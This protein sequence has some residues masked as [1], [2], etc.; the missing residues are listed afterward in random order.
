MRHPGLSIPLRRNF[1]LLAAIASQG[2]LYAQP[3]P[4]RPGPA[5]S[6][7]AA[8]PSIPAAPLLK[9][10]QESGGDEEAAT[11]AQFPAAPV[12]EPEPVTTGTAGPTVF[13]FPGGYGRVPETVELPLKPKHQRPPLAFALNLSEGYDDN[14]LQVSGKT[15]PA[16]LASFAPAVAEPIVGSFYTNATGVA[17]Y[18]ALSSAHLL[19]IN[20]S[21]GGTYYLDRP[22]GHFDENGVLTL[23]AAT[24]LGKRAQLSAIILAGYYAQPNLTLVNAPTHGSQGGYVATA[25]LFDFIYRW[26]KRFNT[27]TTLLIS[28]QDYVTNSTPGSNYVTLGIGQ[29]LRYKLIHDIDGVIELRGSRTTYDLGSPSEIETPLVGID[30][31]LRS[32]T[33]LS[34]R[35]GNAFQQF[36]APGSRK[37]STLFLESNLT[38]QFGRAQVGWIN[39]YGFENGN[40][41]TVVRLTYRTELHGSLAISGKLTAQVSA[42]YSRSFLSDIFGLLPEATEQTIDA[43]AGLEYRYSKRTSCYIRYT[44]QQVIEPSVYTGY[45]E[46]KYFAGLSWE[47]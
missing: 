7:S 39:R 47:F 33:A 21:L 40:S 12:V 35:I 36:D 42:D 30:A 46:N 34:F 9:N 45:S 1:A 44:R 6:G 28:S 18:K 43:S 20:F 25:S 23:T 2:L 17:D 27:D 14:V 22:S 3:P 5:L 38:Q 41:A 19:D 31:I 16:A 26:S 10:E 4:E 15:P 37:P 29:A 11:P 32:Q 24:N 13:S 8:T